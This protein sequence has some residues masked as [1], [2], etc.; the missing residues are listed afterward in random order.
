[1]NPTATTPVELALRTRLARGEESA[2]HELVAAELEPL[3]EFVHYRLGADRALVEDVVQDTFVVALE[4]IESFDG[5]S[6]LCTWLCGIAKNKIR[7]ARRVRRP[8]SLDRAIEEAEPEIDLILSEI[9]REAFPDQVL[10]A[11]ETRE[12]VGATMSS[13]PDD[14][15]EAL[16][17]KYV[18]GL[19]VDQMGLRAG[20]SE[21]AMESQLTRARNAFARVFELLA[22]KRGG[23]A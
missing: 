18:E 19:S 1:M 4:K 15:R 8:R 9:Q 7:A 20:K 13:L 16:L 17:A 10:E 14:Y 2:V 5:R 12:L 6:S 3:Y 22:K 21:K 23:L 11:A